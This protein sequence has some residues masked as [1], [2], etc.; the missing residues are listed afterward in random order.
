MHVLSQKYMEVFG[1]PDSPVALPHGRKASSNHLPEGCVC[2]R[3]ELSS[4]EKRRS[5][6][7]ARLRTT[8]AR[9]ASRPARRLDTIP[10]PTW[11]LYRVTLPNKV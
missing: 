4:L 3:A 2:P 7:L 1:C 8:I 5:L 6:V 11:R 10:V 9:P